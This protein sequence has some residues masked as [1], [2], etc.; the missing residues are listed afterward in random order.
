MAA[1]IICSTY[2]LGGKPERGEWTVPQVLTR[3]PGKQQPSSSQ[4]AFQPLRQLAQGRLWPG[5]AHSSHFNCQESPIAAGSSSFSHLVGP[6][7]PI[8]FLFDQSPKKMIQPSTAATTEPVEESRYGGFTRFELELEVRRPG[9]VLDRLLIYTITSSCSRWP[10]LST[11]TTSP[12]KSY[13][14]TPAL[15]NTSSICS[16]SLNRNMS[17]TCRIPAQHSK[18]WNCCN[19]RGSGG[20]F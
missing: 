2:S 12:R 17:S 10:I 14:R 16:I 1:I 13:S 9:L 11:L 8:H 4:A 15:S 7:I 19:K 5:H 20:T 6:I 18:L 3:L